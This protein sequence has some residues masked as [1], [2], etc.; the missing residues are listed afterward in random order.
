MR[1]THTQDEVDERARQLIA[2]KLNGLIEA[3]DGSEKQSKE[4]LRGLVAAQT[5]GMD[6]RRFAVALAKRGGVLDAA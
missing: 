4:I 2:R 5:S 6:V 1:K 3:F